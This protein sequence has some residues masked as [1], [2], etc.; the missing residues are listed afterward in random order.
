MQNATCLRWVIF[1]MV[2]IW[3]VVISAAR[4]DVEFQPLSAQAKRVVEAMDLLGAPLSTGDRSAVLAAAQGTG[5]P[6]AVAKIEKTLD[7][8]CLLVVDVNPESRVKV[9]RG[10]AAAK[11]VEQGWRTFLIRVNNEAGVTAAL[12]I[13]SPNAKPL[14]GAKP[15]QVP[16]RW[17]EILPYTAQP[18]SPKLSGLGVEYCI[19]SLFSRDRGQR[20]ARISCDVG[21]GTQDLGFRDQTDVLFTVEP[22][23][24][25]TLRVKDEHGQPT[26]AGF[27]IKDAQ[28]RVY[29][30]QAKR[31][32]PDLAF[33][34]QV[35]RADGQTVTL[36]AGHYTVDVTRGPEYLPQHVALDMADRAGQ[37]AQFALKRWIE[38]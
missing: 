12:H 26:E 32:A 23:F 1:A 33:H 14:P 29:P 2:A 20:E 25:L 34:P 36:P 19:V 3:M 8:Y 18:M 22:A 11:L 24:D 9:A 16:Q 10:P 35:Y 37:S 21:Q 13:D 27:V 6:E 38:P 31:L 15:A 28:G 4:A 7:N 17:L 5:G 30:P